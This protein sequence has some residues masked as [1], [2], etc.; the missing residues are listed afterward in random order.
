[1]TITIKIIPHADQRYPTCGDWFFNGEDL[2]IRVSKLSDWRHEM[3]VA[4]HELYEAI[5]CEHDGVT[6]QTVDD[7]DKNFEANRPPGD[8]SE[9]GDDPKAPYRRQHFRA[10]NIECLMADNLDVNF[11][12]YEAELN[13]LDSLSPP[14]RG[15]GQEEGS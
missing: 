11:Q 6:Q 13:S 15:E 7:F 9:P 3:L 5:L 12:D 14:K 8:D 1:M 10:T 2:E 4:V